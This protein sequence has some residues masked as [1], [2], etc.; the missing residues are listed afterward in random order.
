MGAHSKP[1]KIRALARIVGFGSAAATVAV[2]TQ[3]TPALAAEPVASSVDW[4]PII[5]CESGGNPH[6][7]N[8]SSTASGLFQ[9]LDTTWRGLGGSTAHAKD[10]S[11][12]EQYAIAN[13]AYAQS[14]LTPWTAS[15]PCW[16]GKVHTSAPARVLAHAAP[17]HA[18]A[19]AR[20]AS[21]G[22]KHASGREA[23]ASSTS[24]APRHAA[25]EPASPAHPNYTVKSGDTLWGLSLQHSETWQQLYQRNEAAI[26]KNPDLILPGQHLQV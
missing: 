18:P 3:I 6:A 24:S 26:G 15:R 5:H 9:F 12:A 19:P 11:V 2:A 1:T 20:P 14:G 7:Q 8:A 17:A 25:P 13:K 10:A 22:G 4:S 16:G 23:P 21:S